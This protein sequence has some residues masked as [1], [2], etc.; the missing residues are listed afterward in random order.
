M[1][2]HR[3]CLIVVLFGVWLL[4]SGIYEPLLLSFGVL[5]CVIVVWILGRMGVVAQEAAPVRFGLR[6]PFYAPWLLW[7]I[8]RANLDVAARILKPALPIKPGLIRVKASQRSDLGR[9]IYANSITLT[10]GTVSVAVDGDEIAVHA[11]SDEAAVDVLG[12]EMDR[13]VQRLEGKN[14]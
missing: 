3:V 9:V 2:I 13:R 5:S 14:A 10:P 8:V 11:L 7:Q 6:F 1:L 12:G 4:W